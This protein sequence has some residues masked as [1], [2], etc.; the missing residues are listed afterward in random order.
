[1]QTAYCQKKS[2]VDHRRRDSEFEEDYKVYF[3]ISTMKGVVRFCKKGKLI[4]RDV[5][6][7][8]IFQRVGKVAYEFKIPSELASVHPVF[9]VSVLKKFIGD[10]ESIIPI[11][12]LGVLDN[13]FF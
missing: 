4:P 7:D 1:M 11:E 9:L 12:G 2:Y 10:P 3:K 13:L 8:E 6:P 5:G